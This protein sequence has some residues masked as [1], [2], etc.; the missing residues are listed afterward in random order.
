MDDPIGDHLPIIKSCKLP[1]VDV[2]VVQG[3]ERRLRSHA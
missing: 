1:F 3:R 2:R